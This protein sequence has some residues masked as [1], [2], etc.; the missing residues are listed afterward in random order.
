MQT[1][2]NSLKR[3]LI[4]DEKRR[5]YTI[6]HSTRDLDVFLGL[7]TQ[8]AI[9]TLADVRRY[10]GSRRY[11]HF[12]REN[13]QDSLQ[14]E[15]IEYLHLPELGGRREPRPDSANTGWRNPQFR[16]YA[17]HMQT[18]EFRSG[19]ER[20]LNATQ[21]AA[22]MCAEA[23]PW[24]CH[25]QLLSDELMRRG[26]EVVHIVDE[27]SLKPHEMNPRASDQGSHLIYI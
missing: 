21:P 4:F 8:N 25:R 5:V 12:S 17:D 19:I 3:P 26:H 10:P 24:R 7:L 23:V 14:R 16:G 9:R 18:E 20:V 13:L 15:G 6:G 11:P 2:F 27:R 1:S 22:I